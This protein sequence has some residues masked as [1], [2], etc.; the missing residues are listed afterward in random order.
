M[1]LISVVIPVF[2]E[3]K[4]IRTLYERLEHITKDLQLYGW[5]YIF[6]DDG[7]SDGSYEELRQ[8]ASMD[9]KI[10]VLNLSRNFGKE[11]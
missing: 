5:E 9:T 6:V 4:N 2:C 1:K 8:L 3:E 10:K 11:K 7:S